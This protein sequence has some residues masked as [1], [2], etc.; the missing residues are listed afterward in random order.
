MAVETTAFIV[1]AKPRMLINRLR[2]YASTWRLISVRTFGNRRVSRTHPVFER[3]EHVFD[4]SSSHDHGVRLSI[5][6]MLNG[7][8][9][10]F[11]LP[12]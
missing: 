2:L 1:L 5:E 4:R 3:S 10:R 7:V 11:M 12:S 8:D 9:D 6:A